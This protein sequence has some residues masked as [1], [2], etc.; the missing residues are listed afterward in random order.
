M[1]FAVVFTLATVALGVKLDINHQPADEV[2]ATIPVDDQEI[3][4]AEGEPIDDQDEVEV[5]IE[6]KMPKFRNFRRVGRCRL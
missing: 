3:E 1:K 2:E 6:R 4:V 5:E